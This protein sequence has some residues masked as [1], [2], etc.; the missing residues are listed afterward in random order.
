M[1]QYDTIAPRG[2]DLPGADE[3]VDYSPI[4]DARGELGPDGLPVEVPQNVAE[5][6]AREAHA[7][8]RDWGW[9]DGWS[10]QDPG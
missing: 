5:L 10:N 3:P 9:A 6:Y 4:T 1:S 8:D 7:A 2:W